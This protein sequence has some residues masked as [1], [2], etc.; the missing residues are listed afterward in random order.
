MESEEIGVFLLKDSEECSSR[1][2]EVGLSRRVL[3]RLGTRKNLVARWNLSFSAKHFLMTAMRT[4][5][6]VAPSMMGMGMIER[7]RLPGKT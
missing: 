5:G 7:G 3:V 4:V 2:R 1:R 6:V